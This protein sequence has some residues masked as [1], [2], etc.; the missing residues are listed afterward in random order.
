MYCTLFG[1]CLAHF[2]FALDFVPFH[3]LVHFS[4]CKVEEN[5]STLHALIA[6]ISAHFERPLNYHTLC[7][8]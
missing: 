8:S 7:P 3:S 6:S 2:T 5:A 4:T 1:V